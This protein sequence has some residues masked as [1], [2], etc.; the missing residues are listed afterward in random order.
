MTKVTVYHNPRCSKSRG[1]L[2]YLEERG[3][4][5]SVVRYLDTPLDVE[6][7]RALVTR[8]GIRP[9]DLVRAKEPA[10]RESGLSPD[11]TNDEVLAAMAAHPV[12]MERPVVVTGK[13]AA[14]GRP[15]EN[16]D[17]IL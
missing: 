11:S 8:L 2:A 3:I 4:E 7:L 1:M 17:A 15:L 10:Y 12:L 16:V 6:A 5:P 13:G 14:I 9:H